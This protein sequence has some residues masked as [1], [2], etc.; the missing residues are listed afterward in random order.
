M[1]EWT[2]AS[3]LGGSDRMITV[4]HRVMP[5][6]VD[7]RQVSI[8]QYLDTKRATD[9]ARVAGSAFGAW[10]VTGVEGAAP[11]HSTSGN[12]TPELCRPSHLRHSLIGADCDGPTDGSRVGL[13]PI[14]QRRFAPLTRRTGRY[15]PAPRRECPP[16]SGPDNVVGKRQR[17]Q[18]L[19][20][21]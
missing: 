12:D 4:V 9:A 7:A 3:V 1:P 6:P 14:A 19:T 5:V 21:T 20:T 8:G 17:C 10:C 16:R 11:P 18:G 15:N 13:R 2:P